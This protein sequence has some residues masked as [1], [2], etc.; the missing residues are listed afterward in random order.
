MPLASPRLAPVMTMTSE[1]HKESGSSLLGAAD[2]DFEYN[3]HA[4]RLTRLA[5]VRP[6]DCASSLLSPRRTERSHLSA[7]RIEPS[8][9]SVGVPVRAGTEQ[10]AD[11]MNELARLGFYHLQTSGNRQVALPVCRCPREL[12]LRWSLAQVEICICK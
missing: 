3:W 5:S 6:S 8:K 2:S 1:A 11:C 9:Y 10:R 4:I 7:G 12:L